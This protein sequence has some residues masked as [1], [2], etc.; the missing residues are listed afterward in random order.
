MTCDIKAIYLDAAGNQFSAPVKRTE[1]GW[2]LITAHG[3]RPID[4]FIPDKT[5]AGAMLAFEDYAIRVKENLRGCDFIQKV[6]AIRSLLPWPIKP[7]DAPSGQTEPKDIRIHIEP[8]PAIPT[9][10]TSFARLKAAG[11][12][13]AAEYRANRERERQQAQASSRPD[14]HR[15]QQ[16]RNANNLM[17]AKMRPKR[18]TGE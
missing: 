9:A 15:V 18:D 1:S 7:T 4:F 5:A 10:E 6:N 17:A 8:P 13:V 2:R 3:E 11:N 12:K 16:V 14:P